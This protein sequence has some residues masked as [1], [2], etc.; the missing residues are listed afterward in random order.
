MDKSIRL[1]KEQ[2]YNK[3]YIAGYQRGIEDCKSGRMD[4]QP[5]I[6]DCPL[7][8]L[9][10]SKR[11]INSLDRAGYSRIRDIVPLD[12]QEIWRIRNL[13][14]KGLCEIAWALWEREIR[15][16]DWNGWLYSE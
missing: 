13:G 15:D 11:V 2:A 14:S 8:F 3:G 7:Q 5:D 4:T 1:A 16:T 6:L 10:L 9:N 12:P